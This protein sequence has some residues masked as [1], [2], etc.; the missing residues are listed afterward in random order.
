MKKIVLIL[1]IAVIAWIPFIMNA[2]TTI[3]KLYEKYAGK[4]DFTSINIS[5]EMFSLLASLD[6]EDSTENAKESQEVMEQLTGLKMLVYEPKGE[7]N[8][9]F[10]KEIKS[11]IPM[12]EFSELMSVDSEGETVKFLIKKRKDNKISEMMM[13]VQNKDEVVIMSMTGILDMST[14]SSISKSLNINA[15][16]NLEKLD[17]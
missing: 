4:P 17:E 16:D 1:I 6:T 13:I 11:T 8:S 9:N 14:I 3:D 10:I 12:N 2:Q 7:A 15:M 5:P